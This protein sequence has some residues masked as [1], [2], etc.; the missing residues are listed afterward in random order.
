M[1]GYLNS[2]PPLRVGA[3]SLRISDFSTSAASVG[4]GSRIVGGGNTSAILVPI[5]DKVSP[6][7]AEM[8]AIHWMNGNG[9]DRIFG[10]RSKDGRK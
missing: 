3:T 5:T 1:V 10:L 2:Q 4:F 9:C 6:L 8:K 7:L